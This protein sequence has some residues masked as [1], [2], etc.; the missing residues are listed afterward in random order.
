MNKRELR[1]IFLYIALLF[2]VIGLLWIFRFTSFYKNAGAISNFLAGALLAVLFVAPI[3]ILIAIISHLIK[4]I[5]LSKM[6]RMETQKIIW[7]YDKE[8]W[9]SFIR[10]NLSVNILDDRGSLK[11]SN[12]KF[13][14]ISFIVLII[15]LLWNHRSIEHLFVYLLAFIAIV[16]IEFLFVMGGDLLKAMDHLIFTDR[17][18]ILLE[19]GILINGEYV[20]WGKAKPDKL[21][22]KTING[23]NIEITYGVSARKNT[24]YDH[25]LDMKRLI[26]PIPS[27]CYKEAN[28]YIKFLK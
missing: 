23:R 18:V 25:S 15:D 1:I 21:I 12:L 22:D 19:K 20:S 4:G 6:V 8:V 11:K 24:R 5:R 3:V 17:E 28:E 9:D 10:K 13:M 2:C 27:L 16:A 7:K 14:L 26:I